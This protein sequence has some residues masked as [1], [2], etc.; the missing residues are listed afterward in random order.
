[1]PASRPAL[2]ALAAVLSASALVACADGPT[3][4]AAPDAT[5]AAARPRLLLGGDGPPEVGPIQVAVRVDNALTAAEAFDTTLYA[6][7]VVAGT[8]VRLRT[9]AGYAA[10]F[11]DNGPGDGDARKGHLLVEMPNTRFITGQV[12]AA[13]APW[14]A[15]DA[16]A[17]TKGVNAETIS[18]TVRA[19]RYPRLGSSTRMLIAYSLSYPGWGT[20]V[21]VTGPNGFTATSVGD[22]SKY[23]EPADVYVPYP[24]ATYT[25]C[26]TTIPSSMLLD[27]PACQKLTPTGWNQRRVG[28]F[29]LKSTAYVSY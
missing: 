23:Q 28:S 19:N 27:G 13:P 10:T 11:A 8:T 25:M 5:P 21:T 9:E 14:T 17:A 6:V 7:D 20:G 22:G 16:P 2:A 18:M 15:A 1:M 3:A 12:V 24:N 26:L 4:P 29:Q